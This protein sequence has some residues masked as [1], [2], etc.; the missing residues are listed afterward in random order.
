MTLQK[1]NYRIIFDRKKE[2]K[3]RGKGLLEIYIYFNPVK[4][5]YISTKIRIK[6]EEWNPKKERVNPKNVNYIAIN[7]FLDDT[8]AQLEAAE[9][10]IIKNGGVLT[11]EKLNQIISGDNINLTFNRFCAEK[12]KQQNLKYQSYRSDRRNLDILDQ[13][14]SAISFANI[15]FEFIERFDHYIRGYNYSEWY[16]WKIHKTV[17][18]F[19][20]LAIR[21]GF[22]KHRQNPYLFFKMPR[23]KG[24]QEYLSPSELHLIENADLSGMKSLDLFRDLFLFQ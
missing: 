2:A 24:R 20:L 12:L 4:K 1:V 17:K 16:R 8:I 14:D 5:K 22:L 23:P 3:S 7:N 9:Y 18:K 21:Y 15:N 10:E 19:I 11:L 6:S 13:F